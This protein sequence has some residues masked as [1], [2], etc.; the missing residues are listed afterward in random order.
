MQ[1]KLFGKFAVI[2]LSF[3]ISPFLSSQVYAQP[4]LSKDQLIGT[5]TLVLVNN[6]YPDGRKVQLYGPEPQGILVFDSTGHYT[7][8]IMS[9]S[10]PKFAS[11][12]K[13]QGSPEEYKAAVQETNCHFGRYMLNQ[14]D[15]SISFYIEHASF[16]NWE[17]REQKRSFTLEGD[18]LRYV[19]PVPTTGKSVV[20]EVVWRR[21]R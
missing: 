14:K 4:L 7:L 8:Q 20:G 6:V 5:W 16:P 9:K 15:H 17:G 3:L 21:L 11:K 19:V 10:R 18:E 1:R 12:D 2:V 13:S